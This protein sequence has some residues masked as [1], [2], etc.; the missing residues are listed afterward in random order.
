VNIISLA[1][2]LASSIVPKINIDAVR[3]LLPYLLRVMR[4]ERIDLV[5]IEKLAR[6]A[7]RLGVW[8]RL[9]P[10]ERSIIY[11]L[12]GFLK[13]GY[14]VVSRELHMIIAKIYAEVEM[15]SLRG[16]A[17]LIGIMVRVRSGRDLGTIEELLV[18]GL[19]FMN[20][21]IPYRVI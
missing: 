19:Q 3:D 1:P 14:K 17:V 20:R 11:V 9:N 6:K 12:R 7:M 15:Y 16:R 18:E 5:F 4:I 10:F 21:P 8:A 13:K 2:S